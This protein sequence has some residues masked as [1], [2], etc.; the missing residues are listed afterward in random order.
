MLFI[1]EHKQ[2]HQ[3]FSEE[4]KRQLNYQMLSSQLKHRKYTNL[5]AASCMLTDNFSDLQ[6][7]FLYL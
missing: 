3:K 1:Q 5:T 6:P 2:S 4:M 7:D